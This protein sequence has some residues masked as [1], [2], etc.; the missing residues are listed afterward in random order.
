M[1]DA[2]QHAIAVY[3]ALFQHCLVAEEGK[4]CLYRPASLGDSLKVGTSFDNVVASSSADENE[5]SITYLFVPLSS[6]LGFA[7]IS[8]GVS[9]CGLDGGLPLVESVLSVPVCP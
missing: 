7:C 9:P 1:K 2:V 4:A 3:I 6:P 8:L 5:T